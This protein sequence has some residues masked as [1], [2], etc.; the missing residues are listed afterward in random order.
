MIPNDYNTTSTVIDEHGGLQTFYS[1][2][3]ELSRMKHLRF[4]SKMDDIDSIEWDF[5]YRGEPLSLQ[6]N[7]YNGVILTPKSNKA[8]TIVVELVSKLRTSPL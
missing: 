5:K 7:I 6:Y 4:V 1:I 8:V 3:N 2:S